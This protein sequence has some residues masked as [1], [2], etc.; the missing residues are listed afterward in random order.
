MLNFFKGLFEVFLKLAF[1][2]LVI[3]AFLFVVFFLVC[4]FWAFRDHILKKEKLPVFPKADKIHSPIRRI[5]IDF[6]RQ[7][8]SDIYSR[9]PDDFGSQGLIIFTGRQGQ[10]K[11][12]SMV[13]ALTRLK[14]LYPEC[15]VIT[16]FAYLGEDVRLKHW[17]QLIRFKNGNK[18]VIVGIDETQN[19]FSSNQSRNFPPEMLGVITQNRKNRRLILGTAQSFHLLAKSIRTQTTEVRECRTFLG[20]LTYVRRLEPVLDSDG[21]VT[22]YKRLGSY[23]YVHSSE[24][25]NSYDTYKVIDSLCDSGFTERKNDDK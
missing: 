8:V 10:G 18:G 16:N 5:L 17:R 19:W 23:W 24:L 12:I 1:V 7:F 3:I 13:H 25:R 20:C 2:P 22:E 9:N 14:Q 6:P 4:L 21:N 15:K 11:T